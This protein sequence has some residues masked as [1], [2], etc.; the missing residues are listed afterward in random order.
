[1]TGRGTH[2]CVCGWEAQPSEA[3]QTFY[4]NNYL[5][6][7]EVDE[8]HCTITIP[9]EERRSS[10]SSLACVFLRHPFYLTSPRIIKHIHLM[11]QPRHQ[12]TSM[13]RSS[14]VVV[15]HMTADKPLAY[16]KGTCR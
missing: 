10:S 1:M 4:Q 7:E 15:E 13:F 16:S 11:Y 8:D 14:Q 2:E 5:F 9:R 6:S 3:E 12:R